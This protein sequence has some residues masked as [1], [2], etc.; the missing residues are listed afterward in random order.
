MRTTC[1]TDPDDFAPDTVCIW[2]I[3]QSPKVVGVSQI[4]S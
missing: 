3:L 4:A 1:R 2:Q